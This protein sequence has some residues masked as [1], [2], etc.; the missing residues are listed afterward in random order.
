[1]EPAAVATA[2]SASDSV[3]AIEELVPFDE[4]IEKV[5]LCLR[6]VYD[7]DV[8]GECSASS[9]VNVRTRSDKQASERANG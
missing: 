9:R 4:E 2:A 7:T 1:M 8:N 6:T 3:A 5:T